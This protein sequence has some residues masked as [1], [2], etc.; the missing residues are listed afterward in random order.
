MPGGLEK[1]HRLSPFLACCLSPSLLIFLFLCIFH[2]LLPYLLRRPLCIITSFPTSVSFSFSLPHLYQ[3]LH[4][5]AAAIASPPSRVTCPYFCRPPLS[6]HYF[7]SLSLF[8]FW[9]V[10]LTILSTL[11]VWLMLD[12]HDGVWSTRVLFAGH[13]SAKRSVLRRVPLI[14]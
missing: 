10:A 8:F 4:V 3:S 7:S 12:Q 13:F 6:Y 11:P 14:L 2:P 9:S 5:I 1:L